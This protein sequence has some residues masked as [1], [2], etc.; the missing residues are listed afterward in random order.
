MRYSTLVVYFATHAAGDGGVIKTIISEGKGWQPPKDTDEVVV[1]Y[2]ARLK[3]APTA[4]E[5]A[6]AAA[7][8]KKPQTAAEQGLPVVAA[9]PEGGAVFEVGKAPCSG[10]AVALK[11]M[12]AQESTVLVLKPECKFKY[13]R[14]LLYLS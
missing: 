3:P 1:T 6:A 13:N 7:A 5:A 4:E 11:S 12:K 14:V 8:P 2:T 9:S 10:F